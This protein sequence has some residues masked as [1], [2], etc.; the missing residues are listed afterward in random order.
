MTGSPTPDWSDERLTGAFQTRAAS[1]PT[2]THLV[3]ATVS[4]VRPLRPTNPWSRRLAWT[5][6]LGAAGLTVAFLVGTLVTVGSREPDQTAAT[7]SRRVATQSTGTRTASPSTRLIRLEFPV[8]PRTMIVEVLDRSGRL[9]RAM[10]VPSDLSPGRSQSAVHATAISGRPEQVR[11][12]W[13]GSACDPPTVMTIKE[14][15]RSIE[16]TTTDEVVDTGNLCMLGPVPRGVLLTFDG[17][18]RAEEFAFT[19][20]PPGPVLQPVEALG[21]PVISVE[22]ALR[23]R[24]EALDD[25]EL[26][27]FGYWYRLPVMTSCPIVIAAGPLLPYCN[28]RRVWLTGQSDSPGDQVKLPASAALQPMMRNAVTMPQRN[29]GSGDPVILVG[30]F[31]D[32]RA[33]IC[34]GD[35]ASACHGQFVVDVVLD[36]ADPTLDLDRVESRFSSGA[37]DLQTTAEHAERAATGAPRGGAQI[38]AA[39]AVA[40]SDLA[41]HEPQVIGTLELVNAPAVWI[42][43]YIEADAGGRPV[44]RTRLVIDGALKD[45]AGQVYEVT[46]SGVSRVGAS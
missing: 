9:L 29:F 33:Y 41:E 3:S 5:A 45:L 35:I 6:A 24:G 32:H 14:D 42:V 13:L 38:V 20:Q 2:P 19:G 36:P 8:G 17:P 27:V 7:E 28:E 26:A 40:G 25:T 46:S 1:R 43:R 30:H 4:R 15:R 12:D 44:V 23:H 18:A 21:L 11:I 34:T 22:D 37:L 16:F 10:P 31:D 39:F